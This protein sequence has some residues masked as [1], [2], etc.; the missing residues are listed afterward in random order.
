MDDEKFDN[1]IHYFGAGVSSTKIFVV[2]RLGLR[3]GWQADDI[4]RH[5][6]DVTGCAITQSRDY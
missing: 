5:L 4:F 1:G 3:M 6:V 2:E